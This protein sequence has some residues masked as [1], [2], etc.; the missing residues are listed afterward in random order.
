M[1]FY[2]VLLFFE[3]KFLNR[4]QNKLDKFQISTILRKWY[5]RGLSKRYYRICEV[6]QHCIRI[7]L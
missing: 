2:Q 7:A 5:N 1:N 3:D 6:Y 4:N